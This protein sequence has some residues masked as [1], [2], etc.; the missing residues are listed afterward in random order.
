LATCYS[1]RATIFWC[2]SVIGLAKGIKAVYQ[3]VIIPKFVPLEK[4]P[5]ANGLNMLLTGCVSLTLG[6]VI[7]VVHDLNN[8]YVYALHTASAISMG[9]VVLWA[10]YFF[11][12][13]RKEQAE[14]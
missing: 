4:L 3:S 2:V 11:V 14:S 6:P 8:S 12:R 9:C 7:G 10:V 5:A 13:E 1:S